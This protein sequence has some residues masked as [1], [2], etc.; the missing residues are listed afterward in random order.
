ML[1]MMKILTATPNRSSAMPENNMSATGE[2]DWSTY[3]HHIRC[4]K[5]RQSLS[6]RAGA[7]LPEAHA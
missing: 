7:T 5:P 2:N 3:L 1:T 4:Q 6:S